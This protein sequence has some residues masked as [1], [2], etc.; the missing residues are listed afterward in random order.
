MPPPRTYS[1]ERYQ[2]KG[3]R[4]TRAMPTPTPAPKDKRVPIG[5]GCSW[6]KRRVSDPQSPAASGAC[7]A[8][9]VHWVTP[10]G[11]AQVLDVAVRRGGSM[12]ST[13]GD[14]KSA[15]AEITGVPEHQQDLRR[16]LPAEQGSGVVALAD[17]D[18]LDEAG[19][20]GGGGAGSVDMT[21]GFSPLDVALIHR[22]GKQY[23]HF[24][25]FEAWAVGDA[26]VS[27]RRKAE[28]SEA[29]AAAAKEA[30]ARSSMNADA[31]AAWASK[32]S[33]ESG[34]FSEGAAVALREAGTL[35]F[36]AP[37]SPPTHGRPRRTS[38][39]DPLTV[40]VR[41]RARVGFLGGNASGSGAD[42]RTWCVVSTPDGW[43]AEV[44]VSRLVSP[45]RL[46]GDGDDNLGYTAQSLHRP[47]AQQIKAQ[48]SKWAEREWRS[49]QRP[50]PKAKVQEAMVGTGS[51]ENNEPLC[52][53]A[54]A[55]LFRRLKAKG[56]RPL[57]VF[58]SIDKDQSGSVT[59]DELESGLADLGVPLVE[60][61]F[62]A[63]WAALDMNGDGGVDFK[64]FSRVLAARMAAT[65]KK[66][67]HRS[68][69][70]AAKKTTAEAEAAQAAAAVAEAGRAELQAKAFDEWAKRKRRDKQVLRSLEAQKA[71]REKEEAKQAKVAK[72]SKKAVVASYSTMK[73]AATR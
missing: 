34:R 5:T 22:R 51:K 33:K 45:R 48:Q 6:H 39:S 54:W 7:V 55:W 23:K 44:P 31:F 40:V 28:A 50:A 61:D 73:A 66:M 37:G 42:D 18:P 49:L 19:S 15:V 20:S 63:M 67:A 60:A 9:A 57:D 26:E 56:L 21:L 30:E 59:R 65:A 14:V 64:E 4:R 38:P 72:W 43:H 17:D 12:Q 35:E 29:R 70:K 53:G 2:S 16:G 10:S 46:P 32:L 68:L 11:D 69:S 13:V 62:E 52:E 27:R 1:Y 36:F 8:V 71:V 58:R 41:G 25:S 3:Q 24:L 47:S